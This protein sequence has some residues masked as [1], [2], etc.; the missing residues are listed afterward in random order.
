M[1][2]S[3]VFVFVAEKKKSHE[4]AGPVRNVTVVVLLMQCMLPCIM[5]SIIYFVRMTYEYHVTE[6]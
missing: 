4:A 3:N 5:S 2:Q 6:C 1:L